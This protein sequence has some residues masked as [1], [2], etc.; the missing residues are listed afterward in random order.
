MGLRLSA[1][2]KFDQ[3]ILEKLM[4]GEVKATHIVNKIKLGANVNALIEVTIFD[5]LSKTDVSGIRLN[6]Q[7]LKVF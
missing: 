6:I 5:E 2:D 7:Y 1:K 4:S 3:D